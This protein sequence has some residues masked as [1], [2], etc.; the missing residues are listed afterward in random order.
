M[1]ITPALPFRVLVTATLVASLLAP[2]SA[3]AHRAAPVAPAEAGSVAELAAAPPGDLDGLLLVALAAVVALGMSRRRLAIGLVLALLTLA[4]EAGLHSTHH[5]GDPVR[6]AECAL[7]FATAHLDGA[8]V[9]AVSL[10]PAV[11]A[12]PDGPLLLASVPV[13]ARRIP[14]HEGRAPPTLVA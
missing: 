4:F 7:A 1:R 14:T 11:D 2:V 9:D 10:A 6:A 5:L 8:P 12:A 3:W 13:T